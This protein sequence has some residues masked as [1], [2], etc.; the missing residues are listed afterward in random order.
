MSP[1]L[2][3]CLFCLLVLPVASAADEAPKK[4]MVYVGTY[5]SPKKS[6]GIYRMEL[7][8]ATGKLTA[9]VL[10]GK[11]VNPSFLAVHPCGKSLY[12][13]GEIDTFA[14]KGKKTG[15]GAVSAFAIDQKTGDLTLLNQRSS[16]GGGPCHVVVDKAGKYALAANYGGG[17]ACALSIAEDG[18]LGEA[19]GFV[20][21]AGKKKPLAHSINLDTNGRFA[22]VADAGLDKVFV[23]RFEGGKLKANDPAFVELK[24]SAGPRHFAFHPDGKHA[25]VINESALS[26]TA[27]DYDG[28]K[29][30]LAEV[31]TI[32]TV[33]KGWKGGSTAEVVVHPSGKFVYGSNRGHD[34]IAVFA[35]DAMS[36]KLTHVENQAKGVKTPRN[37]AIDPSGKYC[38]VAN[39]DSHSVIVFRVDPETGKLSP[40]GVKVEIDQPVC[41]RFLAWPR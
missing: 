6:E 21:H 25:Y 19:T 7:D 20:Q 4:V 16:E 10:A 34:S 1:R 36:G 9:P 35:V 28:K 23:Y 26:I 12:A 30:T 18:K 17:N 39:Q 27:F 29:G 3:S 14:T 2:L 31:Q 11:A 37:F 41:V 38:L 15:G 8:L 22:V 33:P 24:P 13:V 32:P 40:T 5:T